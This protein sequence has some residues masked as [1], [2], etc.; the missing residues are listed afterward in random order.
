MPADYSP[1]NVP[2]QPPAFLKLA[3]TPL[4][5]GD[6]VF[7]AGYPGHTSLLA[8]AVDM[9]QTES[10]IYP[11]Q[12]AMFDA[13]L[14]LFAQ[15]SNGDPELAIK[16]TGRRRGF[17]NYRTKHLGELEGMK[18]G[19]LLAKKKAEDKALQA[20]ISSDPQ[21]SASY[22][23]VLGDLEQAF[24]EQELTRE[25]DTALEREYLMPRLL[26]AAYRIL[27]MADERQKPDAER[28]PEYQERN[29]PRLRDELKALPRATTQ[30][31]TA[32]C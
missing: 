31:S 9:R 8:P 6:L 16:A 27:R 29:V 15:L 13:Y 32:R 18:R 1:N 25:A 17:D 5:E 21:R 26:W 11:Q 10:V 4:A 7:V 12:L 30:S 23:T 14:A 19:Q 24:A 22:G 28:D 3:T 2:Y 20:F